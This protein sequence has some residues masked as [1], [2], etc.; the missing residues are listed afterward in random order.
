MKKSQHIGSNFDDFLAD[1]GL[2]EEVRAV[3]TKR[4]IA[5]L[6]QREMDA[7]QITKTAMAQRMHTSRTV[8]NRLLDESDLSL[9]LATLMSAATA[10]G[11]RV[12]IS[13]VS[14]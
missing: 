11:K 5:M 14:A 8:L 1:E 10:L 7:Q 9:T 4:V 3:A 13:L 6:I 2:L 12:K